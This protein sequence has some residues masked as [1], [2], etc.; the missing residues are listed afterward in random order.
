MYV[1]TLVPVHLATDVP[2]LLNPG[3]G[4]ACCLQGT[5]QRV[6]YA[7]NYYYYHVLYVTKKLLSIEEPNFITEIRSIEERD[8]LGHALIQEVLNAWEKRVTK[9]AKTVIGEKTVVCGRSI[10]W[11]DEEIQSTTIITTREN[12]VD[13]CVMAGMV[14]QPVPA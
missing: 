5:Q 12:T 3:Q 11:W 4:G 1:Y 6:R 13:Q 7:V 9:V 8:L 14:S 2:A 10:R